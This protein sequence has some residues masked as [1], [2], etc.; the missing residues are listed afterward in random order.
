[1]EKSFNH[2]CIAGFAEYM[3]VSE[4]GLAETGQHQLTG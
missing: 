2:P 1:M 3:V 4:Q